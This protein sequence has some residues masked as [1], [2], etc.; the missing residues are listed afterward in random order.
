MSY[1]QI[2]DRMLNRVIQSDP[3][4][5]TRPSSVVYN[6]LASAAAEL[7]AMYNQIDWALNESFVDTADRE[8]LIKSAN[9]ESIDIGLNLT[10]QDGWSW[11]DVKGY[12]ETMLDE[13][14]SQLSK[15]W[16]DENNVVVRISQIEI[17]LLDITGILDV[18]NT[19]IN[20]VQE[21]FQLDPDSIPIRGNVTNA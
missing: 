12:V 14:F 11:E 16:A 8:Y 10:F 6:A 17:R 2:L 7:V 13:Y 15:D 3:N 9:A 19:T 5:D 21:N 18:A 20:G 4:I 1:D